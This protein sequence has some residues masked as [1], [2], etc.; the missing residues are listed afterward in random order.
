[1][2]AEATE[3][4]ETIEKNA[5]ERQLY[6]D[7][8]EAERDPWARTAH[9]KREGELVGSRGRSLLASFPPVDLS[10]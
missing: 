6:E 1:M 4:L 3:V 2:F 7:L 5:E 9:A 8:L 10:P